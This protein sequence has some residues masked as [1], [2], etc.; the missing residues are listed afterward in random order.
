MEGKHMYFE[1]FQITYW[2][3]FSVLLFFYLSYFLVLYYHHKKKEKVEGSSEFYPSVSL[4][5]PVY[6]EEKIVPKKIQ[7]INELNY[8]RER[9]E[10]VFVDG[11]S[12][13]NTADIIETCSKN[14]DG[15]VR[16]IREKQR[17][18]YNSAICEGVL[19]SHGDIIVMSDAGAY[20]DPEALK[21]L[22]G[23]FVDPMVGAVTGKE[24]VLGDPGA[25]GP[26]LE[27]TYR[28]FYD[29]MRTAE[30]RMDSTPDSK[31]EIL[32]VRRKICENLTQRIHLS[33]SA[34]FDC[35]IPYQAKLEGYRTVFEPKAVYYEYA[36][37]SFT[38]RMRQQIR[39]AAILMGS[40]LLFR[41]MIMNKKYGKFGL[42][43]APV[44]FVMQVI[45]PWLFML[46]C[47]SLLITTAM[48]PASTVVIW[49]LLLSTAVLV[50]LKN[51]AFLLSF[52]QSQLALV[53]AT[54][55]VAT[56]RNSVIIDTIAS[57][58]K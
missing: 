15:F 38:D 26:R 18:G 47:I 29:F 32:A 37:S 41:D 20:F 48:D 10:A 16:L 52:I 30:T 45:L 33:P 56:K 6:N 54:L 51:R 46:G 13:D 39:R 14:R 5:I 50:S 58:R 42:V 43:I 22:V 44:H 1:V 25:L 23:H 35:C 3:S 11:C 19:K 8:P 7:N 27:S 24:M 49:A 9:M 4:I 40:L 2:F 28:G 17:G 12:T 57:T 36:P 53:I 21:Y 55:R 34:S 31:G